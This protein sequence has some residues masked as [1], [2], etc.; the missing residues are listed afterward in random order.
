MPDSSK[1]KA[2]R[3]AKIAEN[4]AQLKEIAEHFEILKRSAV[5]EALQDVPLE[6][7]KIA[8][9][10]NMYNKTT[11]VAYFNSENKAYYLRVTGT[12]TS[13]TIGPL[14]KDGLLVMADVIKDVVSMK[15]PNYL[16]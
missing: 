3:R 15:I 8:E 1:A 2:K 12:S 5:N 9:T 13:R 7:R 4:N 14:K 16:E 11:V 6:Y 10:E